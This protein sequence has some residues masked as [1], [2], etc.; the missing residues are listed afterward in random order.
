MK[1]VRTAFA[2]LSRSKHYCISAQT[3]ADDVDIVATLDKCS[4][5]PED[6]SFMVDSDHAHAGNAEVQNRRRSQNGL[7]IK[8]NGAPVMSESK[9]SSMAFA[10]PRIGEAHADISSAGVEIYSVGNA[11][12]TIMGLSYVVE[13]E[14]GMIF[15]FPFTLEMDK[16]F[17]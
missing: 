8:L 1:A 14:M 12:M 10:T 2:Y 6:W 17:C 9:E 11:T 3:Y 15:P 13:E 5:E 4:L 16:I 7:I